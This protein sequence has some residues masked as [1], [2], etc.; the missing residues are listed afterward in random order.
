MNNLWIKYGGKILSM[1]ASEVVTEVLKSKKYSSIDEKM[2]NR[3]ALEMSKRYKKKK[4][5]IKAVKKEL[6]IIHG[7]FLHDDCHFISNEMLLKEA[8]R[9]GSISNMQLSESIMNLHSSTQERLNEA[10]EIYSFIGQ[11][12]E[13]DF[14]IMDIG[15]GFNPFS[16]PFYEAEPKNYIAYDINA[17]TIKLINSYFD[18][19]EKPS[20]HAEIFDVIL[21]TP[22]IFANTVFLLKLLPLIEQQKKGRVTSLLEELKFD[23][24][25]ISFPLKSVTGKQKGMEMFYSSFME[26][27]L[28]LSLKIADKMCFSNELFFVL[29]NIPIVDIKKDSQRFNDFSMSL[30]AKNK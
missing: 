14:A 27:N 10:K 18:L 21:T 5:I 20:Y 9:K 24:A 3:I 6:H 19:I 26:N 22:N 13:S 11:F 16:I 4:D 23:T 15:C 12:I 30:R 1:D 17:D 29:K 25:I 8:D 2:V 7:L 28:P